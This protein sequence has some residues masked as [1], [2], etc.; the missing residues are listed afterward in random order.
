[1]NTTILHI[2]ASARNTG[3]TTRKVSQLLVDEISA[4]ANTKVINRDLNEALPFIDE[5][6]VGANFTAVDDRSL[7]QKQKLALS[8]L[9]IKELE[10]ADT[11]V[12][13]SPLYNFSIA[14]SL[15][16]WIDLVARAGVTFKYTQSGPIGVLKGKKVYIA[17]ASGG[18]PIGSDMDF[19]HH[20]LRHVLGFIGLTDVSIIDVNAFDLNKA[21][22]SVSKLRSLLL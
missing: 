17:M 22:S 12:I 5:Q 4:R 15:K 8:D 14:A 16:A 3:S 19:A 1:M 2:N 7:E 10:A 18:V 13:G 6:W 20:Y 9:L 21:D 11:I